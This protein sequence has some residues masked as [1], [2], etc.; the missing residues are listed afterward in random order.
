MI[1]NDD[2]DDITGIHSFIHLANHQIDRTQTTK[3][4]FNI[5]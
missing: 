5:K 3:G 1:D 2:D 4:L